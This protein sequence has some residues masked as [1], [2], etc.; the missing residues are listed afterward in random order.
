MAQ[1]A[2]MQ[3]DLNAQ[4]AQSQQAQENKPTA[5][6]NPYEKAFPISA[7]EDFN[8]VSKVKC[9][10]DDA[11]PICQ[12]YYQSQSTGSEFAVKMMKMSAAD[13][14]EAMPHLA[15]KEGEVEGGMMYKISEGKSKGYVIIDKSG[16]V[17]AIS[18]VS[19]SYLFKFELVNQKDHKSALDLLSKLGKGL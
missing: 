1:K 3:K 13:L 16:K 7:G 17:K 2:R 8:L 6:A 12:A 15:S 9:E 4:I 19:G 10:G 11:K 5:K 18:G 14:S